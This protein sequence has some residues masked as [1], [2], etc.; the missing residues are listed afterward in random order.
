MFLKKEMKMLT[1]LPFIEILPFSGN[2]LYVFLL[3]TKNK[4][5]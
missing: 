3:F 2:I 4:N 1:C 5:Q